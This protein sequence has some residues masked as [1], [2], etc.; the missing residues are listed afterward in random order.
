MNKE[1]LKKTAKKAIK[2]L[3]ESIVEGNSLPTCHIMKRVSYS[4]FLLEN[5]IL[6]NILNSIIHEHF[7]SYPHPQTLP[8]ED[9]SAMANLFRMMVITEYCRQNGVKL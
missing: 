2:K 8:Y 6:Y 9:T 4:N 1:E 3:E 5:E 7:H